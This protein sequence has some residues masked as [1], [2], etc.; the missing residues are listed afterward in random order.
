MQ[1]KSADLTQAVVRG[2]EI[3]TENLLALYPDFAEK[4]HRCTGLSLDEYYFCL[5]MVLLPTLGLSSSQSGERSLADR[6]F[7]RL[8]L[9][10]EMPALAQPFD[11]FMNLTSQSPEEL[12][13]ALWGVARDADDSALRRC[14]LRVF[15]E[16]PI[17]VTG[18]TAIVMDPYLFAEKASAGPLFYV[19]GRDDNRI[20]GHFGDAFERYCASILRS[21]YP[22]RRILFDQLVL[23]P[24]IKD[25]GRSDF[26]LADACISG[27]EELVLV[28]TKGVWIKDEEVIA[29]RDRYIRH[30]RKKYV[31]D[32][33]RPAGLSQLARSV[34]ML[35][36]GK[37]TDA[38]IPFQV[39]RRIYPVL[40]VCDSNLDAPLHDWFLAKEFRE[41][42]T[43]QQPGAE[44]RHIEIGHH[45]VDN[46]IVLT[47]DDLELLESSITE[48]ALLDLLRDYSNSHPERIASVHN[49]MVA[50]PKYSSRIIYS[51][52]LRGKF[53]S[54]LRKLEG[55][56]VAPT[57]G[58]TISI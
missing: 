39:T 52:R 14:D 40:L 6:R 58:P 53:S 30:L 47:I 51:H 56:L 34:R 2:R 37:E 46:L 5:T 3:V 41:L 54:E 28:E 24:K 17:L 23:N 20:F 29:G 36:E 32:T 8:A 48:F 9:C 43:G 13:Q 22:Q 1:L 10:A 12:R 26:E 4:F 15:R 42:L 18:T 50:D 7:S 55:L 21:I 25:R 11:R 45:I 16:R 31:N 44:Q 38:S 35:C 33:E 27:V 19:L 57:G 49:F